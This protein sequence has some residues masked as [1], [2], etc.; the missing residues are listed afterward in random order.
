MSTN[1]PVPPRP[2]PPTWEPCQ[3]PL[4][5]KLVCAWQDE[6]ANGVSF[7][8]M[9]IGSKNRASCFYGTI[10]NMTDDPSLL[11]DKIY[12]AVRDELRRG[13]VSIKDYSR[14]V[15]RPCP[16]AQMMKRPTVRFLPQLHEADAWKDLTKKAFLRQIRFY[17]KQPP[18]TRI[19][20]NIIVFHGADVP[21]GLIRAFWVDDLRLNGETTVAKEL[22]DV[23]PVPRPYFRIGGGRGWEW[24]HDVPLKPDCDLESIRSY[25][26]LV[27]EV[28]R[29]NKDFIMQGVKSACSFL[30]KMKYAHND[31]R[32]E[33][34]LLT[35]DRRYCPDGQY[36]YWPVLIDF[37]T[38]APF[39]EV[40][41]FINAETERAFTTSAEENDT[42]A[43]TKLEECV[44]E[45]MGK[46]ELL[47]A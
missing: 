35:L 25:P 38:C 46:L 44:D 11:A 43:L 20:K 13:G 22:V 30:H 9:D 16:P 2:L 37:K 39:G 42:Q 47:R 21:Y 14:E 18:S 26:A 41:H 17:Q 7:V 8:A 5:W 10:A 31:I 15:P 32:P 33:H 3:M 19:H 28:D 34:V 27:S 1:F 40:V 36:Y 4:Q 45:I 23:S 6:S 12:A 29:F 24:R